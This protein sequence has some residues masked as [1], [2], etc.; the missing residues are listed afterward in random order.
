MRQNTL[1]SYKVNQDPCQ[2]EEH[3]LWTATDGSRG[4]INCIAADPSSADRIRL[5]YLCLL[6]YYSLVLS[7][8]HLAKAAYASYYTDR[9]T[10]AV[11][12]R[13]YTNVDATCQKASKL[14]VLGIC[15]KI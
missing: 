1:T 12:H 8:T 9:R 13:V 14:S 3:L 6:P 7:G 15:G 2:P 5:I 10:G 4:Y 11:L